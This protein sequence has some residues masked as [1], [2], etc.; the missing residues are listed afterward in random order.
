MVPTPTLLSSRG[1]WALRRRTD[2]HLSLIRANEQPALD[3]DSPESHNGADEGV[4][5]AHR[6]FELKKLDGR[7]MARSRCESSISC[8]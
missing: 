6:P 2:V 8:N 5:C 3:E 4:E 1:G 7:R